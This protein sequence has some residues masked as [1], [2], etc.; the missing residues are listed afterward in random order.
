MDICGKLFRTHAAGWFNRSSRDVKSY[1][2]VNDMKTSQ[3]YKL[4]KRKIKKEN[5]RM[6]QEV[7]RRKKESNPHVVVVKYVIKMGTSAAEEMKKERG[8]V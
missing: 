8:K 5:K 6:E 3:N 1:N 7:N 2:G 4:R